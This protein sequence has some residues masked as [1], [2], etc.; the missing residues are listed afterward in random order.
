MKRGSVLSLFLLF[1]DLVFQFFTFIIIC[2]FRFV[3]TLFL[4]LIKIKQL[5][6][7]RAGCSS[8]SAHIILHPNYPT[9]AKNQSIGDQHKF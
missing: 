6:V 5:P 8:I 1:S 3:S 9:A 2:T 7:Q 4:V